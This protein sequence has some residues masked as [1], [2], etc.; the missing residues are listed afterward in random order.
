MSLLTVADRCP[1]PYSTT[2]RIK[3]YMY[4]ALLTQETV[5]ETIFHYNKD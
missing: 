2:T 5:S 4:K 3:T 1:R